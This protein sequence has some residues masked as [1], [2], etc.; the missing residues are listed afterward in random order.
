VPLRVDHFESGDR[1]RKLLTVPAEKI[2][3]FEGK[4]I[5]QLLVLRDMV[6]ETH[7]ELIVD[8]L[9]LNV[10]IPEEDFSSSNLEF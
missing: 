5:P 8:E 3:E 1:L 9:E 6:D 7:T 4:R 10:E 2:G